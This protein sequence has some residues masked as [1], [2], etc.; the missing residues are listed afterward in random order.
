MKTSHRQALHAQY[1]MLARLASNPAHRKAWRQRWQAE[2]DAVKSERDAI[3]DAMHKKAGDE[4][5]EHV[6]RT[7]GDR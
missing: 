6:K 1:R 5:T 3:A 2:A 4:L 7:R